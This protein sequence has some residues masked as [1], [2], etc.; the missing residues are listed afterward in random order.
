MCI[1]DRSQGYVLQ[2]LTAID[3]PRAEQLFLYAPDLFNNGGNVSEAQVADDHGR[4]AYL[5]EPFGFVCD[6][7]SRYR[8][9]EGGIFGDA[10]L[11]YLFG[12]RPDAPAGRISITSHL[13]STWEYARVAGLTYGDGGVDIDVSESKG[14]RTVEVRAD[15]VSFAMELNVSVSGD[16]TG[17]KIDGVEQDLAEYQIDSEWGISRITVSDVPLSA[18]DEVSIRVSHE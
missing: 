6:L 14:T 18:G 16:I 12:Y 8:P 3:H 2:G 9:W 7:T 1:R 17:L 13:P 15:G 5:W 4:F 10:L 11:D